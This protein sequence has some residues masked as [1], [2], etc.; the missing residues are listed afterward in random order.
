MRV[1]RI[2]FLYIMLTYIH[3][4]GLPGGSGKIRP[5]RAG[6]VRD[7]GLIPVLGR[8]LEE[9]ISIHS[10]LL[11]WSNP[12]IEEPGRLQ[13]IGSHRVGHELEAGLGH[14]GIC[15]TNRVRVV[16]FLHPISSI[17]CLQTLMVVVLT[18]VRF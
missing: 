13:C 17:Y 2:L 11:A 9:G 15:S 4:L 8:S 16:L 18:G 12:R 14:A 10:S 1:Y 7:V 5:A 6:A 3:L